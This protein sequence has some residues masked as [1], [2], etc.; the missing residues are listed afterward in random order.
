MREP[1]P[2]QPRRNQRVFQIG[3]L[4][5]LVMLEERLGARSQQL[6]ATLPT[7]F[8]N[9]FVQTGAFADPTRT[10]LGAEQEA[11]LAERL[12]SSKARW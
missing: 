1:D 8:G 12:R 3:D 10:L 2:A 6:P 7:P 11:W 9:G 5:D 4:V